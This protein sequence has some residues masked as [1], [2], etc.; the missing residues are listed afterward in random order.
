MYHI[1]DKQSY[2]RA[3]FECSTHACIRVYMYVRMYICVCEYVC[4]T[5]LTNKVIFVR[6]LNVPHTC[7]FRQGFPAVLFSEVGS[8]P[9]EKTCVYVCACVYVCVYVCVY[10]YVYRQGFPA[11][12]LGSVPREKTCVFVYIFVCMCV[13]MCMYMYTE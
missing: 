2:I 7:I 13:C 3:M 9:S 8:V 10:L 11:V 12:R 4:I 6:C 5:Y 1:P